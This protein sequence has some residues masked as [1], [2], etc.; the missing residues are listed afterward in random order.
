MLNFTVTD[1]YD[2][3][4]AVISIGE[5]DNDEL[6]DEFAALYE[7]LYEDYYYGE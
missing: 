1:Y 6:F 4:D 7:T 2:F 5:M 3:T